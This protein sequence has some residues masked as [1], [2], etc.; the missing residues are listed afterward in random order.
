M[1][2]Y[3]AFKNKCTMSILIEILLSVSLK[4]KNLSYTRTDNALLKFDLKSAKDSELRRFA[5]H[6][7]KQNSLQF[8]NENECLLFLSKNLYHTSSACV[9]L[10]FQ[11]R[12]C[13]TKLK[14]IFALHRVVDLLPSVFVFECVCV[15]VVQKCT[16]QSQNN[17]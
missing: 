2:I 17:L 14:D 8:T 3:L 11:Q 4:I 13:H 5:C 9:R 16:K 12:K 7:C 6:E 15:C 10:G 1:T